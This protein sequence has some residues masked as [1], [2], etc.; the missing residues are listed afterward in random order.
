MP[1]RISYRISDRADGRFDVTAT[2]EPDQVFRREGFASLAAAE[3][4]VELLRVLMAAC[5]APLIHE[6]SGLPGEPAGRSQGDEMTDT[7][8]DSSNRSKVR[9]FAPG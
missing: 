4:C 3:E 7:H 5:S 1:R 8:S 2:L 9:G 6:V